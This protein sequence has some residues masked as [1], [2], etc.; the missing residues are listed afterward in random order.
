MTQKGKTMMQKF[1]SW[2]AQMKMNLTSKDNV[3]KLE[4]KKNR[5]LWFTSLMVSIF[6][7]GFKKQRIIHYVFLSIN[8]IT[9][10]ALLI[11]AFLLFSGSI[12]D[13]KNI[14][15]SLLEIM[16]L[17]SLY[18]KRK[19][20]YH[21]IVWTKNNMTNQQCKSIKILDIILF[22]IIMVSCVITTTYSL[23]FISPLEGDDIG[24]FANITSNYI[25]N[26]ILFTIRYIHASYLDYWS[27][28]TISLYVLLFT[29]IYYVKSNSIVII[30]TLINEGNFDK[31]FTLLTELDEIYFHF[32]DTLSVFPFY[33]LMWNF[34]FIILFVYTSLIYAQK[35]VSL[36]LLIAISMDTFLTVF[37]SL[38]AI[39]TVSTLQE[40]MENLWFKLNDQIIIL[41]IQS[42]NFKIPSVLITK[43]ENTFTKPATVWSLVNIKRQIVVTICSSFTVFSVL[44]MQINNGALGKVKNVTMDSLL[45]DLS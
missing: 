11:F 25:F 37:T 9:E 1:N 24:I 41:K 7:I 40:K 23:V 22:V 2:C 30:S 45:N 21:L 14:L 10:F 36:E 5:H 6:G 27:Q 29:S 38:A 16:F 44:F 12:V 26:D 34:F 43:I 32:E 28:I 33:S 39:I 4:D 42:E 15:E 17:T 8:L 31:I 3:I 13:L 20:I 35:N 18:F 19:N